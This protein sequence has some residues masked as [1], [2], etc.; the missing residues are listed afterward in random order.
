MFFPFFLFA[1]GSKSGGGTGI[2]GS[3]SH[4]RVVSPAAHLHHCHHGLW[5]HPVAQADLALASPHRRTRNCA[6]Q[7]KEKEEERRRK[8][9][10]KAGARSYMKDMVAA[11]MKPKMMFHTS[12]AL[13]PSS[14]RFFLSSLSFTVERLACAQR[15]IRA[16]QDPLVAWILGQGRPISVLTQRRHA[17]WFVCLGV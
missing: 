5:Q 14:F 13:S 15:A 7:N 16:A 8:E 11:H 17:S 10:M 1:P 12:L 3:V 6:G 2:F 9:G 4:E